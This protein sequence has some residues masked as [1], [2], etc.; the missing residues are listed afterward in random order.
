MITCFKNNVNL[1]GD[2][3]K[4]ISEYI[5]I[6]VA[7]IDILNNTLKSGEIKEEEKLACEL[8]S[9]MGTAFDSSKLSDRKAFYAT[10]EMIAN[11]EK[12]GRV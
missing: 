4:V 8:M 9:V 5:C 10:I 12:D 6:T 1:K 2:N 3:L 7:M 11:R